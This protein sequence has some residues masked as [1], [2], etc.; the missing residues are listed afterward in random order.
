MRIVSIDIENFLSIE[1]AHI[2]FKN[3]GTLLIEG[4]NHDTNSANGA[5]KTSIVTAISFILY[6]KSPRISGSGFVR[7][8]CKNS[9]CSAILHKK[10]DIYFVKRTKPGRFFATKNNLEISEE[11]F[12]KDLILDYDTFLLVQY[13]AQ[14]LGQRFLDLNDTDR[15]DLFIRL[16][17]SYNFSKIKENIDLEIKDLNIKN[18]D[19]IIKESSILAK[20]NTYKESEQN[21]DALLKAQQKNTTCIDET[22]IKIKDLEKIKKPDISKIIDLQNKTQLEID[23]IT[24]NKGA[25]QLLRRKLKQIELEQPPEDLCD[26]ICPSC[27]QAI[28][29]VNGDFYRHDSSSFEAKIKS[30][31]L[32]KKNK[33]LEMTE[34][35]K[36]LESSLSKEE[37]YKNII[38]KC[39][40]K[41]KELKDSYIKTESRLLELK[42]FIKL[43]YQELKSIKSSIDFQNNLLNNITKNQNILLKISEEKNETTNKINILQTVSQIVSPTGIQA[44]IL[45]S[46]VDTFND[47]INSNLQVSWPN[48]SYELKTFKENKS[49]SVVAKMSD[50]LTIN[51]ESMSVGALS[52]GE[53]RNLALSIDLALLDTYISYSGLDL[54]P[55]ILDEPFDHLDFSNRSRIFELLQE[56]SKNR[57]IIV[58]DHSSEFKALFDNIITVSKKNDISTLL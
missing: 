49:G 9:T 6:G 30:W 24:Q 10:N 48:C 37:D 4:W 25:S 47:K 17:N 2:D 3:N 27:S 35:I 51:G 7:K 22:L 8:N 39:Q 29:I 56:S 1:K 19:L 55:I 14:G 20:I 18:N 53:R 21:I 31:N 16:T 57:Q 42:S 58:I 52:G 5:G 45:D 36:E 23:K 33:L 46:V 15:K 32:N 34:S 28:D 26:G 38:D 50:N 11:E 40:D 12:Y 13:F 44:Y 54:N 43:K 41:I